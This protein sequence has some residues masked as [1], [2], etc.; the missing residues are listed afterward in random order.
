[1]GVLLKRSLDIEKGK[2]K[3]INVE[4]LNLFKIKQAA[5]DNYRL[6]PTSKNNDDLITECW[7]VAIV[8]ELY[9]EDLIEFT[10]KRREK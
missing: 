1:M 6:L 9:R 3:E 8:D 5:M 4:D 7:L 2:K 10:I